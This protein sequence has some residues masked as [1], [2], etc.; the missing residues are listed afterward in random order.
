MKT[1]IYINSDNEHR[2]KSYKGNK[3]TSAIVNEALEIYF[4]SLN[5]DNSEQRKKKDYKLVVIRVH[6]TFANLLQMMKENFNSKAVSEF[7]M[8]SVAN[9]IKMQ[10]GRRYKPDRLYMGIEQV[11]KVITQ[12]WNNCN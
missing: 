3:T 8:Y 1:S 9:A 6:E 11:E 10:S 4:N 2:L 7:I 12:A 5:L